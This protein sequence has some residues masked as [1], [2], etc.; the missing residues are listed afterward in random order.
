[1]TGIVDKDDHKVQQKVMD[2]LAILHEELASGELPEMDW[3]RMRA[4]EFQDPL[5]QRT[6]LADRLARFGCQL[7]DEFEEHVSVVSAGGGSS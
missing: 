3:S 1:V 2:N 5:R 7:C 6:S 4:I